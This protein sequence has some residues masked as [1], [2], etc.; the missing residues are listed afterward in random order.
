MA[1]NVSQ[2]TIQKLAEKADAASTRLKNFK[3]EIALNNRRMMTAGEAFVGGAVG[4]L[5]DGRFGGGATHEIWGIP[6]AAGLGAVCT[7]AGI[8]EKVPGAE[9][10]LGIGIGLLSYGGGN[11]VK[12]SVAGK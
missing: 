1:S 3:Q 11:F 8:S 12:E 6:T 4:G 7:L 9:D 10:L 5:I 2:N